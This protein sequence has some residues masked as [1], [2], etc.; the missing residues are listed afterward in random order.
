MKLRLMRLAVVRAEAESWP[1]PTEMIS[2]DEIDCIVP[3][4]TEG[5][6]FRVELADAQRAVFKPQG[7]PRV[8]RR[9]YIP[10]ERAHLREVGA[11]L[12]SSLAGLGVVP[13]T[14]LARVQ[15]GA[16][17]WPY[18]SLQ[19]WVDGDHGDLSDATLAPL[20]ALD[21]IIGNTDR[22][23]GNWLVDSAGKVWGFD[24]A[25]SFPTLR[26]TPGDAFRGQGRSARENRVA[27][28]RWEGR[29]L[30]GDVIRAIRA[31][32]PRRVWR[33]LLELGF[34]SDAA[35][36]ARDRLI[37]LQQQGGIPPFVA[38]PA[39]R[40]WRALQQVTALSQAPAY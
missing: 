4:G 30:P 13:P 10:A 20:A 17:D 35:N 25:A 31:A 39:A 24:H 16:D 26:C 1:G 22:H 38:S 19:A 29:A 6:C 21:Y 14:V 9:G 33:E 37:L 12:V 5:T 11:Y 28:E 3:L 40:L 23:R 2:Q 32:D 34:E 36:G 18:G 27:E 8:F 15:M 7:S